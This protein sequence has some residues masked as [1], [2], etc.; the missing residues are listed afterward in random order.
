MNANPIHYVLGKLLWRTLLVLVVLLAVYVSGTRLL[1]S[2]LPAYREAILSALNE[3]FDSQITLSAIA[4]DLNGFTPALKFRGLQVALTPAIEVRFDEAKASLDPWASLLALSP[5]LDALVIDGA[6]VLV[7]VDAYVSSE[8]DSDTAGAI[9]PFLAFKNVVFTN[10][11]VIVFRTGIDAEKFDADLRLERDGSQLRFQGLA[12][13]ANGARLSLAGSGVGQ[14][15]ALQKFSGEVYAHISS[16][17]LNAISRIFNAEGTGV[18]DLDLWYSSTPEQRSLTFKSSI[19]NF[20][21]N[22]FEDRAVNLSEASLSGLVQSTEDGWRATI[23]DFLVGAKSSSLLVDKIQLDA[24]EGGVI[25]AKLSAFDVSA[26]TETLLESGIFSEKLNDVL[27]TLKPSGTVRASQIALNDPRDALSAWSGQFE[28]QDVS[29]KPFKKVPGLYGIDATIEANQDIARAWIDTENFTLDLPLVYDQPIEVRRIEGWLDA[30]WRTNF[31]RLHNG[32]LRADTDEH[33]AQV[34][35]GMDIPLNKEFAAEVPVAMYLDVA[36]ADAPLAVRNHYIPKKLPNAL[37]LWLDDAL[38]EGTVAS[39]LFVWRGPFQE[40]GKGAQSMQLAAKIDAATIQYQPEWPITR[41]VDARLIV[42]TKNVALWSDHAETNGLLVDDLVLMTSRGFDEHQL[43]VQGNIVGNTEDVVGFLSQSPIYEKAG[44]LLDDLES[45]GDV[46]GHLALS[47]RLDDLTQDVGVT[48]SADISEAAIHSKLLDITIT[49]MSG[50]LDFDW[51]TGFSDRNLTANLFSKP[52]AVEIGPGATGRD[53]G[54]LLDARLTADLDARDLKSWLDDQLP[55]LQ[56]PSLD[57]VLLGGSR[58]QVDLVVGESAEIFL[59]SDLNGLEVNLP[60]PIGK[61]ASAVT[62]LSLNFDLASGGD[63]QGFWDSRLTARVTRRVKSYGFFVD[64][65]PRREPDFS[66]II[67]Q[68]AEYEGFVIVGTWPELILDP[69]VDLYLAMTETT[70]EGSS[71]SLPTIARL[72]IEALIYDEESRGPVTLSSTTAS[73]WWMLDFMMPDVW[74]SL[75]LPANGDIPELVLHEL[76]FAQESA[77]IDTTIA[78]ESTVVPEDEPE[79]AYDDASSAT[80]GDVDL[81]SKAPPV[82]RSPL[83]ITVSNLMYG[84]E[85]LGALTFQ[86]RSEDQTLLADGI[87]GSLAATEI[88]KGSQLRW[89]RRGEDVWGSGFKGGI[90]LV[91]LADTF[92]LFGLEPAARSKE[93]EFDVNLEWPGAP[94]AIGLQKLDGNVQISLEDGSFLP[95]SSGATGAV[96]LFSLLNLAG[97]LQRANVTQLFEPGVAFTRAEGGLNFSSG[98]LVIPGFSID[99]PGGRFSF[100]SD[101]DLATEIIDGELTV[102]LPLVDNIPWVAALA[103]GLPLA[104]G[105]YLMS[106]VFEDQV[107]TLSSAVYDV[108]GSIANPDVEFV[109]LFDASSAQGEEAGSEATDQASSSSRK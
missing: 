79:M 66:A 90:G 94:T 85:S 32:V 81:A 77:A 93:G 47:L 14:L 7:D 38:I 28:V 31:L 55:V 49:K 3:Q 57:N 60:A 13:G 78:E 70:D 26:A 8:S 9:A 99:G 108:S 87:R 23:N 42:D 59:D 45:S 86:L 107:K 2:T 103:G 16:P 61:S 54:K 22:L 109:R 52:I 17:D 11:S 76:N 40:F 10:A 27:S 30:T 72:D 75:A 97:L 15:A 105:A 63:W 36:F 44:G 91:N 71:L 64:V 65:T 95:V 104:A 84:D 46:S 41:N 100:A 5:R 20:Q 88:K 67:G 98:G 43:L 83:N 4:G 6:E 34:L 73:K 1:F 62:P 24:D 102:T 33:P 19:D 82:L 21:W 48:L 74:G 12:R 68:P 35:F 18:A 56:Q 58:I 96:R 53:G 101:I 29:V 69:W 92:Q 50:G 80:P 25:T 51:Q 106:K 89:E 39:G 37:D